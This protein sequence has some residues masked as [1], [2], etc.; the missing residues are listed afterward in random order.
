MANFV[1]CLNREGRFEGIEKY[2]R[3]MPA[4]LRAPF[5]QW[6]NTHFWGKPEVRT[7]WSSWF[8]TQAHSAA[9]QPILNTIQR[10]SER[11][12]LLPLVT[13]LS[14]VVA[15]QQPNLTRA[16]ADFAPHVNDPLWSAQYK[17]ALRTWTHP[18][19]VE[20][21]TNA[22][23]RESPN[24]QRFLTAFLAWT[25]SLMA[26]PDSR[27]KVKRAYTRPELWEFFRQ[28][29]PHT[30]S[31]VQD[32][33]L[34]WSAAPHPIYVDALLGFSKDLKGID[35]TFSCLT[36]QV[37]LASGADSF[38]RTLADQVTSL[39]PPTP[40][41]T[42]WA[43]RV[44]EK[45]R[46]FLR[47]ELMAETSMTSSLCQT[48]V[49]FERLVSLFRNAGASGF[50][51]PIG[52]FSKVSSDLNL[53]REVVDFFTSGLMSDELH[54]LFSEGARENLISTAVQG[55]S[56][57]SPN[58]VS[59]M[60]PIFN[61]VFSDDVAGLVQQLAGEP[62][63]LTF[64]QRARP[65]LA[66]SSHDMVNTLYWAATNLFF[67]S[68]APKTDILKAILSDVRTVELINRMFTYMATPTGE[69]MLKN[70]ASL[71]AQNSWNSF[72]EAISFVLGGKVLPQ[73]S[74]FQPALAA[75]ATPVVFVPRP[76]SPMTDNERVCD[77]LGP[78]HPTL[79]AGRAAALIQL[80]RC[81]SVN[82]DLP[83]PDFVDALQT[84]HDQGLLEPL[85]L[86]FINTML[87]TETNEPFHDL[88]DLVTQGQV[89][90]IFSWL[91]WGIDNG[92]VDEALP[93]LSVLNR[94]P[95]AVVLPVRAL[96]QTFHDDGGSAWLYGSAAKTNHLA[97]QGGLDAVPSGAGLLPSPSDWSTTFANMT[98]AAR[99]AQLKSLLASLANKP[100][101]LSALANWLLWE[102]VAQPDGAVYFFNTFAAL[103]RFD[104]TVNWED[105]A[106]TRPIRLLGWDSM[107]LLVTQGNFVLGWDLVPLEQNPAIDVLLGLAKSDGSSNGILTA[108]RASKSK[109]DTGMGAL[110]LL[111]ADEQ[112]RMRHMSQAFDVL[113]TQAQAGN[114]GTVSRLARQLYL[115]APAA[116]RDSKDPARSP[117][118][119]LLSVA[120]LAILS[121]TAE[122][123]WY[124]Q[125]LISPLAPKMIEGFGTVITK[126]SRFDRES[127]QR[128]LTKWASPSS[129]V[130]ADVIGISHESG[131]LSLATFTLLQRAIDIL[132]QGKVN[133]AVL[134]NL[135]NRASDNSSAIADALP[136]MLG[137][138]PSPKMLTFTRILHSEPASQKIAAIAPWLGSLQDGA[139]LVAIIDLVSDVTTLQST[140]WN[141]LKDKAQHATQPASGSALEFLL[142]LDDLPTN[143]EMRRLLTAIGNSEQK[144][145]QFLQ[146]LYVFRTDPR[147]PQ[148]I[149]ALRQVFSSGHLEQTL[150]KIVANF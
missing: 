72:V 36:N 146:A 136:D 67:G 52:V 90:E 23:A 16:L 21:V 121:N 101:Q 65:W 1:G 47:F 138:T 95:N 66:E 54:G 69:A 115:S 144:T 131:G 88:S 109:L 29:D 74:D 148:T 38:F 50:A 51:D 132:T 149:R 35:R 11:N 105:G 116:D 100:A 58:D 82:S 97:L 40:T 24:E 111:G 63:T 34:N 122:G 49:D 84:L 133:A 130:L 25:K 108:L 70:I 59:L 10:L 12:A 46:R 8:R 31:G 77:Q 26:S 18:W 137:G 118:G 140:Q 56:A 96:L 41:T 62:T 150:S 143:G 45:F 48:P 91:V 94:Q 76:L 80:L 42:G 32:I 104:R 73:D 75:P 127:F 5:E 81:E 71:A 123:L 85:V 106:R 28:L 44:P 145:R 20:A 19:I 53:R 9:W 141:R 7:Q 134:L 39:T 124:D 2:F 120:Q 103:S 14:R 27:T 64:F 114:M 93:L 83:I 147:Y 113:L 135:L 125:Q 142:S 17:A 117:L 126:A 55:L 78:G 86:P 110:W 68:R 13:T 33:I 4:D 102:G 87:G 128:L 79:G 57:A 112:R 89:H 61:G 99:V 119:L 107:E 98:D 15:A 139:P 37:Q 6:V 129:Q 3:G 92:L 60:T 22:W 43:P 30:L